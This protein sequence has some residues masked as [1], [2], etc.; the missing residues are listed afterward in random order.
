MEGFI[1]CNISSKVVSKKGMLHL[2]LMNHYELAQKHERMSAAGF[3]PDRELNCYIVE[4]YGAWMG[5][6][7]STELNEHYQE[8]LEKGYEL[9][10][11][12]PAP[13][14]TKGCGV[15][16]SNYLDLINSKGKSK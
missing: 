6:S 13:P 14:M 15:F 5:N 16:C 7:G 10:F 2:E 3:I 12:P 8:Y 4:G 9:V 1:Q 11:G